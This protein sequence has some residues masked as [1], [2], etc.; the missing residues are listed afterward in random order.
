MTVW[1]M[2]VQKHNR[3]RG[4]LRIGACNHELMNRQ[5]LSHG[6]VELGNEKSGAGQGQ[7]LTVWLHDGLRQR[8]VAHRRQLRQT[9]RHVLRVVFDAQ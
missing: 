9:L 6:S 8:R 7:S 3:S 1:L 4:G 5:L 2:T